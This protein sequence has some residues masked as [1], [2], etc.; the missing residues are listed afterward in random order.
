MALRNVPLPIE[1]YLTTWLGL[2]TPTLGRPYQLSTYLRG[3]TPDGL[4]G[5][6]TDEE[7]KKRIRRFD[8]HMTVHRDDPTCISPESHVSLLHRAKRELAGSD[9]A[10]LSKSPASKFQVPRREIK[11][12][13]MDVSNKDDPTALASATS[14]HRQ[15]HVPRRYRLDGIYISW[16]DARKL[17][18]KC[19][20]T[21]YRIFSRDRWRRKQ[22]ADT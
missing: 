9:T 8:L 1:V 14:H 17:P 18:S 7:S 20:D 16:S 10:T 3:P 22:I 6:M 21:A 13:A 4:A 15:T 11:R 19:T 2:M 5:L 12:S